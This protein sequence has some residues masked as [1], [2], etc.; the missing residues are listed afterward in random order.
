M[1]RCYG[2]AKIAWQVADPTQSEPEFGA[3]DVVTWMDGTEVLKESEFESRLEQ[4]RSGLKPGG[5]A[6]LSVPNGMGNGGGVEA[7]KASV[8]SVFPET[9][10]L[11][12]RP[13]APETEFPGQCIISSRVEPD[14]AATIF[15]CR[16]RV[17]HTIRDAGGPPR[18]SVVIALYNG[19][20][21]TEACLETLKVTTEVRH[22]L[23]LVDNGSTDGTGELLAGMEPEASVIRNG[24]NL[25]FARANNLGARAAKGEFL[26]FLNNDT[27]P[28]SG[29]LEAM[30]DEADSD[31]RVGVVGAK[32]LYPDDQRIQHAGIEM[33]DGTPD[34]VFRNAGAADPGVN[35]ARDLDMVTGACLLIRRD[36]FERLGGFDEGYVNGVEDVDLCLRARDLGYKVRYCPGA[37]LEHHEGKTE[38]RYEHVE[39]N[40]VRFAERWEGR[41]D[42]DGR[43]IPRVTREVGAAPDSGVPASTPPEDEQEVLRGCWEGTQFVTHSLSLVNMSLTSELIRSDECELKLIPFEPATFGPEVDPKRYGPIAERMSADLTGPAQFHVRHRW[44]PDF[45]PPPEG[46]WVMMQPWEFGRIPLSWVKPIQDGVDE[47]W[48]Y[49]HSVK[50]CY[51]ESGID[52]ERVHVVPLGVDPD[53]FHPDVPPI[54]LETQKRF[55]FLFVGGTIYR[56]GIDVLLNAFWKAFRRS[57]DVCLVIKGMGDDSFY[58][59]QTAGDTIRRLQADP[60]GP[61]I[62]YLTS[63]LNGAEIAGLYTACDALVHPYRGEGFGLGVAE[64]MACGLPVI[65]TRGGA[66]DDFCSEERAYFVPAVEK[67][68]AFP[69]ETAGPSW[70][71]EPDGDALSQTMRRVISE[72]EEAREKGRVASAFVRE[73]LT[74]KKSSERALERLRAIR[75]NAVRR[76]ETK[77][78]IRSEGLGEDVPM[79]EGS[80]NGNG[81]KPEVNLLLVRTEIGDPERVNASLQR[82]S[83]AAFRLL[84]VEGNEAGGPALLNAKLGDLRASYVVVLR[85]DVAV[86]RDWLTQLVAHM[87]CDS[88]IALVA[89]RLPFGSEVQRVKAGYKSQ[90]KEMQK[91]A[92]RLYL[93]ERGLRDDADCVDTAC[94]LIRVEVLKALGGF[95]ASFQTGAFLQDFC[96][97]CRQKGYRTV[98]ARDTFV[99]CPEETPGEKE[100]HEQQAVTLLETGDLHRAAGESDSAIA[101]YRRA[102]EAKEDYLEASLVLAAALLE[103]EQIGDATE[104]LQTLDARHPGSSRIKNYLARCFYKGGEIEKARGLFEEAI[105][106]DPEFAEALSNL[107]VLLWESGRSTRLWRC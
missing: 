3:Y 26:L 107:G 22:E 17:T 53:L 18:A 81:Q 80:A 92:R 11:G 20:A 97:R 90:E 33:I 55:K 31:P 96:R 9:T 94:F 59:G 102:L 68:V 54:P 58:K 29:W 46:H 2:D 99:D 43:F 66:C 4:I 44:P 45:N 16:N 91:F 87:E 83:G 74:W 61:E 35:E 8:C 34:H 89:P 95:D 23:V 76:S 71:L 19:A 84:E 27:L 64:A 32:L 37:V 85:D 88:E 78:E 79:S 39:P 42:R 93:R 62:H 47:V 10:V 51:V 82:F 73:H 67:E 25:G 57:D 69:E 98:I 60:N 13:W 65:V 14:D 86:T 21:Y 52:P 100:G 101:C 5:V 75:K 50:R 70:I 41:F 106:L 40:L 48:A 63:E 36:L 72:Q 105:Q 28:H 49:T 103:E 7:V 77:L 15:V 1:Q 38:G 24:E 104:V 30:I 12:Q 56:K 6:L